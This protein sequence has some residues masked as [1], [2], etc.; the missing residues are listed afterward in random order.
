MEIGK[1]QRVH[2]VEPVRD[3]VPA[4]P[5]REPAPAEPREPAVAPGKAVA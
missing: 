4:E 3:P 5:K 2:T 1:P